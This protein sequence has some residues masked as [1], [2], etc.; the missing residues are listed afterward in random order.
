MVAAMGEAPF[1]KLGALTAGW[2][3]ALQK[4]EYWGP[5]K[6]GGPPQLQG[7]LKW[8]HSLGN[9]CHFTQ[10]CGKEAGR[11]LTLATPSGL[12]ETKS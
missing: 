4:T 3:T 7:S 8:A 12:L 6:L 9:A 11:W 1:S 5:A 2:S 10:G